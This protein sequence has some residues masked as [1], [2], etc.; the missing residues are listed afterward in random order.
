MKTY[1]L[2]WITDHGDDWENDYK[3]LYET[4]EEVEDRKIEYQK[5][6][7]NVSGIEHIS[8][9]SQDVTDDYLRDVFSVNEYCKLH[10]GLKAMI[11]TFINNKS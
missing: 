4:D 11:D 9:L 2:L 7:E 6:K 10:M 8:F 3:E 1:K 5:E